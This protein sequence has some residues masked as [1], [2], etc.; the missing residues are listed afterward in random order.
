MH[1]GAGPRHG[2]AEEHS[3]NPPCNGDST[4]IKS[5]PEYARWFVLFSERGITRPSF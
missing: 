4:R 2:S 3:G 5:G 1:G